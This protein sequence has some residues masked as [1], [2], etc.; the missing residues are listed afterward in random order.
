MAKDYYLRTNAPSTVVHA[1]FE[2]AFF[3]PA[4][5]GL[6]KLKPAGVIRS[7]LRWDRSLAPDADLAADL[8]EG[9][10]HERTARSNGG[11]S[12]IG[13]KV[14]LIVSDEGGQRTAQM[15]LANYT[16]RMGINQ[17]SNWLKLYSGMMVEELES[18]GF[19]AAA[20]SS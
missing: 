3:G 7:Q 1:A 18:A 9:G 4:P 2:E 19:A 12:L 11:A 16:S 15:W 6:K 8:V 13:T 14:C 5:R 20:G 10:I 17:S